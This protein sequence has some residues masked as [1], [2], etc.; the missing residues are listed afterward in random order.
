M[1]FADA[2]ASFPSCDVGG[3]SR[4]APSYIPLTMLLGAF[5]GASSEARARAARRWAEQQR[6]AGHTQRDGRGW[7]VHPD[8]R[9]P[10][11][12]VARAHLAGGQVQTLGGYHLP[13]GH[14]HWS[15]RDRQR[16]LDS[17]ELLR[18]FD[19]CRR[20]TRTVA[21]AVELCRARHGPWATARGLSISAR[22]LARIR[23]RLDPAS[24][25][26]DGN[27]DARG[28]R[29][30]QESGEGTSPSASPEAWD[31]F[32]ALWLTPQ[33][34]S[35]KLC[36][37]ITAVEAGRRG[38]HWPS[39]RAIQLRVRRELPPFV[40]DQFRLGRR[41]GIGSVFEDSADNPLTIAMANQIINELQ[42]ALNK[43]PGGCFAKETRHEQC[44]S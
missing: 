39:L 4:V 8:A 19:E 7:L 22:T 40:A 20:E 26:F 25:A 14:E 2:R 42:A 10:N 16:F 44:P 6:A 28:R 15:D 35:V 1:S 34:R 33:R 41:H 36:W 9:L 17:H 29:R 23:R 37:E 43:G 18:R 21:A 5:P 38:W 32:K 13:P 31:F 30:R 27:V 24:D 3:A 12:L 11:G